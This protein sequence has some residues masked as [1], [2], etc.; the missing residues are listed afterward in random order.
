MLQCHFNA[1]ITLYAA[2]PIVFNAF[3]RNKEGFSCRKYNE[4]VNVRLGVLLARQ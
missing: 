4:A 1:L 2:V 3:H